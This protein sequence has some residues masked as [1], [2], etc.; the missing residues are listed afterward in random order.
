MLKYENFSF[1]I[2]IVWSIANL[3]R[4]LKKRKKNKEIRRVNNI[5]KL[6]PAKRETLL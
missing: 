5:S 2:N 6:Y 1:Y 4:V 3:N